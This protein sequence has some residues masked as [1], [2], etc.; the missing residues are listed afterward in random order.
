MA[1]TTI[2]FIF[3]YEISSVLDFY[4]QMPDGNPYLD[5]HKQLRLNSIPSN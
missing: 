2:N 5:V 3:I 1:T 4:I